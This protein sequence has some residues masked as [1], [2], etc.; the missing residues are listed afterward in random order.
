M[1]SWKCVCVCVLT[2]KPSDTLEESTLQVTGISCSFSQEKAHTDHKLNC[3]V[4]SHPHHHIVVHVP[5]VVDVHGA[6]GSAAVAPRG[7]G[8]RHWALTWLAAG[9]ELKVGAVWFPVN[10]Q[11]RGQKLTEEE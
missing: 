6:V 7:A 9:G 10:T 1:R 4:R 8:G 2:K 5:Q 3:S 11:H